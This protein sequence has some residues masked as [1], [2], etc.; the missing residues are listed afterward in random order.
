[1]ASKRIAGITIEIGGD[2][3]K[4]NTALKGVDKQLSET[5]SKLRDVNKL[6]KMDPGNTELLTQ[7]QKLLTD[8]ISG[9]EERL[10]TLKSVQ[11]ESVSPE[12]WDNLQREI[13]DTEG[14]LED[15]K[16]EYKDFGSVAEQKLKVVGDKM[17]AVGDKVTKAGKT[18]T[19]HVTAPIV[20]IGAAAVK[21]FNDVDEGLDTITKKTGATG[22][23]MDSMKKILEEI[24]TE[25]PTDFNTAG[26]AIGEVNTRFGVTDD[27]LKVLSTAFIKFAQI[28][29]SDVTTSV[30]S[31]QKALGAFGLS[32]DDAEHYL[33]VLTKT[34]QD[35]GVS[36]DTLMQGAVQNGTAF[37]QMGL[38]IDQATV[39][40]GQMEKSGANSETVMQGLRKALKSATKQ[41][42]PL[43]DA[44]ANLQKTIESGTD[45][46]DG[47]TAAYDLFGKS[48][49]QIYA[50]VKNG[51]LNFK[52]LATESTNAGGAVSDTFENTL[53]PA[54]KFTVALNSMKLLGADIAETVMPILA[55][56]LE[57]VRDVIVNLKSRWD[58]LSES[59]KQMILTIAGIAAAVG[60]VLVVAGKAISTVGTIVGAV[61][62]LKTALSGA[63]G[64]A[65]ILGTG[66]P[67]ILAITAAIAA[68]VL[69]Y[70]NWDKIKAG[71]KK[72]ADSVGKAWEG[73]KKSCS[74]LG[75]SIKKT[76]NTLATNTK[77]AWDRMKANI[78]TTVTNMRTAISTGWNNFK[79][80][81]QTGWNNIKSATSTAWTNIKSAVS[82]G[83]NALKSA[84]STGMTNIKTAM[85]T[86]WT[87]VKDGTSK[88]WSNIKSAASTG[89]NA[90][91]G[92]VNTGMGLVK[93]AASGAWSSIKSTASST[94][95][96]MKSNASTIISSIKSNFKKLGTALSKAWNGIKSA[97]SKAWDAVK[98]TVS[99]AWTGIKTAVSNGANAV[100]TSVSNRMTQ[101]KTAMGTGWNNIKTATG[102]A[103]SQIRTSVSNGAKTVVDSV[104]NRMKSVKDTVKTTWDNVKTTIGSRLSSIASSA[105]STFN[106][107]KNK[108]ANAFKNVQI[109]NPF[110][111]LVSAAQ[112]AISRVKSL[113]NVRLKFPSIKMPHFSISG[114]FSLNPPSVPHINVRWYKKAYQNPYLF[115]SPTVLQTPHGF[116]GFGDGSGGELVY[117]RN[118]LL[119]DIAQA[120]GGDTIY[121]VNV[122]GSEGMNVNQLAAAV[123]NRLVALQRQKELAC[124]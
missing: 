5:Q 6:L 53:D 39:F 107:V 90:V 40:M 111:K 50:A 116:K 91:K 2:A 106:N 97:A 85:S 78:S 75:D 3:T 44:L 81:I 34:S 110:T 31:A 33:D 4:L 41:G 105:S 16:A 95:S 46:T 104:S 64:L 19:T 63:S 1:M 114:R 96:A 23:A 88:A 94:F 57:K 101:V 12:Q 83:V 8:A 26:E 27:K 84:V 58:G 103:W 54:D 93:S 112:T 56:V 59:Q 73:F 113:F 121:N 86:A 124:V 9:T 13:A 61:G 80:T 69:I 37:Q 52:D 82:T 74:Q 49:D 77:Q 36:V 102:T 89:V 117:G 72:L 87:A 48:G 67:V 92:A 30:D 118:Q 29:D 28:N 25:I 20:G 43:N 62:K 79:T 32:A 119:R 15:L 51:T 17:K 55:S 21:A 11:K 65:G 109:T 42:I 100:K 99:K 22:P 60:P 24:A 7:K 18:L 10:K 108:V 98:N 123:Q 47:L 45:S 14:K 66:G 76:W 70:K 71:A 68:G 115:S 38:S 120:S 122:Y 35:T